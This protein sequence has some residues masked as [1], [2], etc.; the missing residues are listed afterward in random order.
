MKEVTT[1]VDMVSL[2][3]QPHLYFM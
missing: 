3:R 1:N 2:E